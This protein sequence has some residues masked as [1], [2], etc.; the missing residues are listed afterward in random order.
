MAN[1]LAPKL[2]ELVGEYQ[3][4]FVMERNILDETVITHEEVHQMKKEKRRGFLLKLDFEKPYDRVNWDCLM[5]VLRARKFELTWISWIEN[6]LKSAK[7]H[8][9]LNGGQEKQII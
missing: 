2:T 5:E 7:T 8:I 4:R 3:T 1:R 9:L 6:W